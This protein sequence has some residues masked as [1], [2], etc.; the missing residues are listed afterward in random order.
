MEGVFSWATKCSRKG[1]NDMKRLHVLSLG[2]GVGIGLLVGIALPVLLIWWISYNLWKSV[3]LLKTGTPVMATVT[4]IK[5]LETQPF[6]YDSENHTFR[7][8]APTKAYHLVARWQDPQTGKTYT[9]RS[10]VKDADKFPVGSSVPF[11]IDAQ[12]P[13]RHVLDIRNV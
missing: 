2:I 7:K 6:T 1:D 5:T 12:H 10:P 11:L 9:L 13:R 3:G 8:Q 4:R